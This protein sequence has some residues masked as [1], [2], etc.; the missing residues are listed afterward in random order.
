MFQDIDWCSYNYCTKTMAGNCFRSSIPVIN[1]A[2]SSRFIEFYDY[3]TEAI[4]KNPTV[5][6]VPGFQSCGHGFKSQALIKHCQSKKLRYV[7][8]DPEA[9]GESKVEDLTKLRFD[10]WFE[11]AQTAIKQ[12]QSDQIVLV[13]S[14]MGGWIS[15]KMA[16][17][18]PD[19]ICGLVLLAPAVNFLRPKYGHW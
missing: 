5:L 6:F 1:R 18:N 17:E 14:S 13:G 11:D 9:L 8:Y 4:K 19:V 15:L 12:S 3:K 2:A 7:C 16:N 10:H